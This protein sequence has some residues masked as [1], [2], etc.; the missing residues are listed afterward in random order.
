M[1]TINWE[2]LN[3]PQLTSHHQLDQPFTE[4]EI[5]LAIED[6]P[7]E[8]AP[9]PDDF[10]GVFYRQCWEV[11]KLDVLAAFQCIYNQTAGPL[12]KLNGAL[13]TLLRKK[14]VLESLGTLG[15]SV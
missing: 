13:L 4:D 2:A 3:L 15:R 12:L 6:L 14:D 9:G 11:I 7:A 1:A 5:R 10:S 8:K